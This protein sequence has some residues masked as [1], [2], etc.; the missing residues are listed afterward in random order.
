MMIQPSTM[1]IENPQHR[2]E[3]VKNDLKYYT[4]AIAATSIGTGAAIVGY[5]CP[6][7]FVKG[8]NNV[9]TY[10]QNQATAAKSSNIGKKVIEYAKQIQKYAKGKLNKFK[11]SNLYAQIKPK[12]APELNWAK[13]KMT[14]LK[15]EI[16]KACQ[17]ASKW[18]AKI[19]TKYKIAGAIGMATL[20]VI[21]KLMHSHTYN[22][23][24]IDGRY[25]A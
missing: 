7:S 13:T 20:A 14:G 19:P 21:A 23:G 11:A 8:Y 9:A 3:R 12:L 17:S 2:A 6:D 22:E 25:E 10:I 16:N 18:L 5:T 15:T 24:K 1:R 4:P